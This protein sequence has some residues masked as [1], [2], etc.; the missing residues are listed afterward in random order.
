MS[1]SKDNNRS[2]GPF[3]D[4]LERTALALVVKGRVFPGQKWLHEDQ[5]E[6]SADSNS[7]CSFVA[8]KT[9]EHVSGATIRQREEWWKEVKPMVRKLMSQE[10]NV[11]S[12][13]IKHCFFGKQSYMKLI[14]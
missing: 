14:S 2:N 4:A 9:G 5:L 10:R 13:A 6:F 8:G 12:S 3:G 7:L 11:K 1:D